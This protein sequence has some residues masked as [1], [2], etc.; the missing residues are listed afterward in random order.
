MSQWADGN[1]RHIWTVLA[2]GIVAGLGKLMDS[3]DP[4]SVRVAVGRAVSSG[5]LGMGS[6][7][8]W[9]Q[10]PAAPPEIVFGATGVICS[11]GTSVIENTLQ[12]YFKRRK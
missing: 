10:Y 3:D 9:V 6:M 8:I 1:L 11:L 2:I 5:I 7:L 12:T 4:L